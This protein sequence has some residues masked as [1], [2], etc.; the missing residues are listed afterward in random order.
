MQ[1]IIPFLILTLIIEA[2]SH[3]TSTVSPPN[4]DS[5]SIVDSTSIRDS[6]ARLDSLIVLHRR[7]DTTTYHLMIVRAEGI[8]FDSSDSPITIYDSIKAESSGD[9]LRFAFTASV[10]YSHVLHNITAARDSISF[11]KV[12]GS[13]GVSSKGG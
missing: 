5:A 12:G 4:K 9:S 3:S 2:C 7:I 1:K 10:D 8:L 13:L 11:T 6:L